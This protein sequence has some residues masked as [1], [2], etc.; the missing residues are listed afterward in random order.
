MLSLFFSS[1][2]LLVMLGLGLLI[3]SSHFFIDATANIG[4][5]LNISPLIM[6]LIIVGF[7]TSTPEIMVGI[8]AALKNKINIAIGNAVGSNIA[9]IGLILGVTA[10]FFP[11][12]IHSITI[13]KIYILMS[14]IMLIPLSLMWHESDLSQYDAIILLLCL[15]ASFFLLA[16]IAKSVHGDDPV[17]SQFSSK[18]SGINDKTTVRLVMVLII[19]LIC[20]LI[21][22]SGLVDGAVL[23]AR[24]YG[25]SD[26]VIGLTIV[27]IGTSLPEIAASITS[28]IKGK[29]DIAIGNIIGSNMFNMLAVLGIPTLI[30]PA[31][32]LD[33]EIFNRDFLV[34]FVLTA[35]L[36]IM[37]FSFK[38][39]K[40][41]RYKGAVLLLC[42]VAYQFFI[43]QNIVGK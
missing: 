21:G 4:R 20:L 24:N 22:A 42:F 39:V 6:G 34:L 7:A 14:I 5:K 8:E 10:L 40:L 29:N 11:F 17:N 38:K 18:L 13:K 32:M 43:Y 3:A 27:A 36:A 25:I 9:N 19:S 23:I 37:L 41:S 30:Q 12:E 26:L 31:K 16:K 15:T 28:V 33:P 35:L 2:P 1:P